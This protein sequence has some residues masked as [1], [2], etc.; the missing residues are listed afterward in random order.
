MVHFG[1]IIKYLLRVFAVFILFVAF[2]QIQDG[3]SKYGVI[4]VAIGVTSLY[5]S[6]KR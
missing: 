1:P 4:S 2:L 6:R 5:L 3:Y